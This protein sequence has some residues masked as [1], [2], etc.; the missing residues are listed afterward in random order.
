MNKLAIKENWKKTFEFFNRLD[1]VEFVCVKP[2]YITI[3]HTQP[4]PFTLF[5]I[6]SRGYHVAS[7][8]MIGNMHKTRLAFHGYDYI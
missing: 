2:Y 5:D 7:T 1:N 8:G 6:E 3:I 4:N